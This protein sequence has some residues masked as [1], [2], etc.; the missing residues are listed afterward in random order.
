MKYLL[1]VLGLGFSLSSFSQLLKGRVS[2]ETGEPV[3]AASIYIRETKQ[4]LI[5]NNE[6]EFQLKV[7]P[8]AY[9]LEV[10]CIGYESKNQEVKIAGEDVD[11]T[12]TLKLK[13]FQLQEV[14]VHAGEDP[15]YAIMRHA[16]EKA[17]YYQYI[18]K[19]LAYEAYTKGSGKMT[20]VS[21]L[22]ETVSGAKKELEV[23]KDKLFMQE[24]FSEIKFTA[25]DKYE[26]KVI[27]F[28][29]TF[30]NMN[31]PKGAMLMGMSSLYSPMYSGK[32][33]PL[34]PK[35]FDYYRFRYEGYDEEDGQII[36]KIRIIPKLKDSKLMEGII[37]IADEEWNIRHA[38]I[39]I[40]NIGMTNQVTLN[41][42]PVANTIYLVTDYEENIDFSLLGIGLK[43]HFLSSI[44]I[45]DI[46]LNDS[47]MAAQGKKDLT[48]K[49]KEKKNLEIKYDE[50]VQRTVDSLAVKRDSL[51]W[52][53][54]RTV[55][56]NEEELKSY[57]RKD[58]LQAYTDS[59]THAENNPKFDAS[60]LLTGGKLGN[61]SSL[62][63]F[64]Y[65][66][67]IGVF[68]EYNWVDGFQLGQSFEL[69]FKKKKNTGWKIKPSFYWATARKTLIWE[70]DVSFDYAPK[71]LGK[72]RLSVGNLSEDFSGSAGMSRLGNS[73][74]SFF[75]G[76]NDLRL[77][78][79]AYRKL[80]NTIDVVNGLQ[81]TLGFETADRQPLTCHTNWS[82]FG[83]KEEWGT[84][85]PDDSRDLNMQ[86]NTLH[87]YNVSLKYTPEYYYRITKG[88]KQYVR[89]RFPTFGLDYQ[90]GF[91]FLDGLFND[92]RASVFQRLE[93]SVKQQLELNLF[94]RLNY[95][96][97]AGKFLNKNAFN[98]IDYKHFNTTD[99]WLTFKTWKNSYALLPYY[100][101]PTNQNWL[102][103]F[104]NYDTDYLVLKRLPFLQGKMFTETLQAKFL[105]T[106]DK[107]YY[108]EWG[109]SV[110]LPAGIGAAGLFVSFDSF[111]YNSLGVQLSLPLFGIVGKGNQEVVITVG[112]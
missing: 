18:V 17:P 105:H 65:S 47:L 38:E 71:R 4:G 100:R 95:T 82:L 9:R 1:L 45:T 99:S 30:P 14:E 49:K 55:V 72:V 25:P 79:N 34:N 68:K 103:A 10:R 7:S 35:A 23:F 80:S 24:A 29:S 41:Y 11:L 73:Y 74:Y 86:Y 110:A 31:D 61:D 57:E 87:K 37:Y 8:G 77:Y 84:N 52:L 106:P 48:Q 46:Q 43:A 15:A 39:T 93:L 16:I 50:R 92:D 107:K 91:I 22:L 12:I 2:T 42:H 28:S 89:S 60:D 27:A 78:E 70:T 36:N 83:S 53:D 101:Y 67:L 26:Q 111:R 54:I 108:S 94:S 109:Y 6:G 85:I 44:Q 5:A 64:R 112:N 104:V 81:L 19:E 32:L 20:N 76:I 75:W 21:K 40:S 13:D 88:K 96:L 59:L 58:S 51:Y 33:S 62:M 69:D 63:Y 90:Q 56:L 97:I 66:G 3:P 102:Q 98:Y